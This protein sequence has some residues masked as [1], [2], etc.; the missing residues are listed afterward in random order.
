MAR[1]VD[2]RRLAAWR[3]R[4]EQFAR[5]GLPVTR[6]CAAEGVS[7]ASFYLWRK[8]LTAAERESGCHERSCHIAWVML[9]ALA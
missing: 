3:Q 7:V 2:L 1:T 5:S 6:F 8:R 9:A 4:L